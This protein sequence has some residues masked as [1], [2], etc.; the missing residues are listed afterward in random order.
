MR[1][2]SGVVQKRRFPRFNLPS[3]V[4]SCSSL[5]YSFHK[6]AKLLQTLVSPHSHSYDTDAKSIVS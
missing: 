6:N 3:I 4:L 1:L 2:K 5:C